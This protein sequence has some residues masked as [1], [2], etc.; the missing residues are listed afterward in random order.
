MG[1]FDRIRN[2]FREQEENVP[3]FNSN[4]GKLKCEHCGATIPENVDYCPYC[5]FHINNIT[6]W[7]CPNCGASN[8]KNITTCKYCG[9]ENKG[10]V[11]IETPKFLSQGGRLSE[12]EIKEQREIEKIR[13]KQAEKEK[14][15]E[16]QRLK[17]LEKLQAREIIKLNSRSKSSSNASIPL[18][19]S[20]HTSSSQLPP[21]PPQ[22]SLD[23]LRAHLRGGQ[24]QSLPPP[25]PGQIP[26]PGEKVCPF[27]QTVI[28]SNYSVCPNCRKQQPP[29]PPLPPP[30]PTETKSSRNSLR[31]S[32]GKNVKNKLYEFLIFE[33]IGILSLVVPPFF[34]FPQ[35]IYLAIAFMA[36][37]PLYVSM[38]SEH[39]YLESLEGGQA[40]LDISSGSLMAKVIFKLLAYSLIIYQFFIGLEIF[41]IISVIIALLF[42]F[43]LYT[44][45]KTSQPYKMIEAWFRM[46]LGVYISFI[47]AMTFGGFGPGSLGVGFFYIGMA[48]FFTFPIQI[49]DVDQGITKLFKGMSENKT[50]KVIE[51]M[52]FVFFMAMAL[53][54]LYSTISGATGTSALIFYVFWFIALITG[55]ASG[56][57]GRPAMGIIMI[58]I[59][60]FVLTS[61]YPGYVGSAV[62]GYWWPQISSFA[63]T[64][65]TPLNS[66]LSQAQNGIGDV[67]LM[68]TN[69]QQYY[70]NLEIKNRVSNSVIT[71][72][73]KSESIEIENF[74]LTPSNPGILEPSEPVIGMLELH[75][76]GDFT[77]GNIEL[78]IFTRWTNATD[79]SEKIFGKIASSSLQCSRSSTTP[80][81]GGNEALCSW[82][83]VYPTE[84][85]SI[86]FMLQDGN[87]GWS[88]IYN[89]CKDSS[90]DPPD[91]NCFSSGSCDYGNTTY[92]YGGTT[93]KVN[94]N[95][96]YDYIVNVSLPI[97]IMSSEVYL[98]KLQA[99]EIIL[100]DLTS[101]YT[102]GP[103]KATLYSPKQPARTYMPFLIQASILNEGQGE[104]IEISNFTITIFGGGD[105][106][107]SVQLIGDDFRIE[108]PSV[109]AQPLGCGPYPHTFANPPFVINC[110]YG[111]SGGVIKPG[112]FRRVSFYITPNPN[113]KDQ[114]TTLIVGTAV[115]K[116]RKTVSQTLTVANAPPQ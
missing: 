28:P 92:A 22:D 19:T 79:N 101:E 69:P 3:R 105:S 74:R 44:R 83:E 100:Q 49:E 116:Y 82:T 99:G 29:E 30:Q 16:E 40:S 108:K 32:A 56:P 110:R 5:G 89:L 94:V 71:P 90:K 68:M 66:A 93:V 43:S 15:I 55:L 48:F 65:M 84:M 63:D 107:T 41:R 23:M 61:S 52:F 88:D 97:T 37:I 38:P 36:L 4:M 13:A 51:I 53:A 57:E 47:L 91:C 60:M 6:G 34:G 115:Y 59:M 67:W 76:K 98:N 80:Q 75:N 35:L 10:F 86:T 103:I 113:I 114:K 27:C 8:P 25:P 73:G 95:L 85:S 78:N 87:D 46:S 62:F 39:Q 54:T 45:Y 106:V 109:S 1:L 18:Q 102:G 58:F 14:E 50:F 24:N 21:P 70:L 7:T 112:E 26:Q 12:R 77:S 72:G 11:P 17:R 20:G 42:Y 33:I 2:L 31:I 96:T 64:Y 104:L 81:D 111:Y 9:K